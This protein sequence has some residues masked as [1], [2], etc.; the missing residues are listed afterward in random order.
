MNQAKV[1]NMPIPLV[2]TVHQV[3]VW[4]DSLGDNK[5]IANLLG[6]REWGTICNLF[7]YLIS[8]DQ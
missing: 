1:V 4:P 3:S 6:G 7:L 5:G 2:C 8:W